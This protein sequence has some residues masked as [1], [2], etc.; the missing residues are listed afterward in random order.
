MVLQPYCSGMVYLKWFLQYINNMTWIFKLHELLVY[1]FLQQPGELMW[2]HADSSWYFYARNP[3]VMHCYFQLGHCYFWISNIWLVQNNMDYTYKESLKRK[4]RANPKV[5]WP[6]HQ[7]KLQKGLISN[8]VLRS[9]SG[10]CV[11]YIILHCINVL[12]VLD[13]ISPE[14]TIF[15][16]P[17]W[18][19]EK[20]PGCQRSLMLPRGPSRGGYKYYAKLENWTSMCFSKNF[21]STYPQSWVIHM[22]FCKFT[23][24][25]IV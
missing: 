18:R 10:I 21:A 6:I 9:K 4:Y 8:Q 2:C 7:E 14:V 19:G 13:S 12:D 17:V 22:N 5:A 16:K 25:L 3:S 1:S 15:D 11:S 24:R 23:F 20:G